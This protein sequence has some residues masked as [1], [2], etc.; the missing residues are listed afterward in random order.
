MGLVLGQ[1]VGPGREGEGRG[2]AGDTENRGVFLNEAH[3]GPFADEAD[4][5]F[6]VAEEEVGLGLDEGGEVEDHGGLLAELHH[7]VQFGDSVVCFLLWSS[8]AA[9][10]LPYYYYHGETHRFGGA[11]RDSVPTHWRELRRGRRKRRLYQMHIISIHYYNHNGKLRHNFQQ[12]KF[13]HTTN[14]A[15]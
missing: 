8:S 5:F 3:E 15:F 4:V 14:W 11:E 6:E 10:F 2:G 7:S 12:I 1:A 13:L 9:R